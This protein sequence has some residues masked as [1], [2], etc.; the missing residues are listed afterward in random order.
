[1]VLVVSTF[2]LRPSFP[3]DASASSK[4]RARLR[5]ESGYGG[6]AGQPS[7]PARESFRSAGGMPKIGRSDG[8]IQASQTAVSVVPEIEIPFWSSSCTI[9]TLS[10]I[11]SMADFWNAGSCKVPALLQTRGPLFALSAARLDT[12]N[13]HAED[14][15]VPNFGTQYCQSHNAQCEREQ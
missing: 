6:R 2:A 15:H 5:Q 7:G 1:M 4:S 9:L 12:K 3:K 10:T 13:Q 14:L 11:A 8:A